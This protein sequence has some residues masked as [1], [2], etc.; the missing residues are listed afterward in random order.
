[1]RPVAACARPDRPHLCDQYLH[2]FSGLEPGDLEPSTS[3][4]YLISTKTAYMKL[5]YLIDIG[6]VFVGHG[7]KQDFRM[8]NI[9]VP[10]EQ[11]ID[12]VELFSFKHKRKLSLRFLAAYLLGVDIQKDTHD[13]IEDARTA[14]ALHRAYE[15]LSAGGAARFRDTLDEIYRYGYRNHFQI[16]EAIPEEIAAAL[17]RPGPPSAV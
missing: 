2:R 3:T 10:P 4:H 11:V 1:M 14:L 13:S 6:C 7:L 17:S 8:L 16:Q 9:V 12:T 5:R 15:K